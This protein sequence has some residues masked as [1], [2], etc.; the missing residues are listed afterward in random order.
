MSELKR[1]RVDLGARSYDV[2]IGPGLMANA[3]AMIAPFAPRRRVFVVADETV[4]ALYGPSL[5][6]ALQSA[7][8][9][10]IDIVTPPG[11]ETK[12]FAHLARVC[13]AALEAGL[14]RGDL[15]VAFGGG[16]IGDLAGFAAAILMRGVDFVQIPTT[17]L[18]QVDSSVGGKTAIDTRLGKNLVGAFHQ[19]RLV[20]ADLDVLNT[21]PAREMR[22]GYAEI[23]KYGLI[24]DAD[25]FAWC[26]QNG[27]H[28]LQG[29]PQALA[30]AVTHAVRA[31]ARIVAADEREAGQRALLNFGHTFAHAFEAE[32]GFGATLLH[33]EAVAAGMVMAHKLSAQLNAAPNDDAARVEAH[34]RDAGF[35]TAL[36]AILPAGWS[37]DALIAHMRH[38]K[39]AEAGALAFVL[40]RGIGRAFVEKGVDEAPVRAVLEAAR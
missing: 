28:L 15:L 38:D 20:I 36:N 2:A 32:T 4:A 12:S 8:L 31:K 35:A 19:P 13:D 21:L 34:L 33:G 27:Q 5:R 16:V 10:Q 37:A 40:T 24:D 1:V 6:G 22:A 9:T 17:L 30:H 29:D 7:G 23:V 11:E 26:E 18:A 25:F 14:D 39:K 3:G